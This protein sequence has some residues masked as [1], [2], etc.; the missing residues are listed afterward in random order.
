MSWFF[1]KT[2]PELGDKAHK[3]LEFG[4]KNKH[5]EVRVSVTIKYTTEFAS[6]L[7]VFYKEGINMVAAWTID[8]SSLLKVQKVNLY[9]F[10]TY[11]HL[12]KS[13][14]IVKL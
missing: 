13:S 5:D 9:F 7:G 1:L 12:M 2:R 3:L 8:V 6:T 11:R 14:P 4:I 10:F